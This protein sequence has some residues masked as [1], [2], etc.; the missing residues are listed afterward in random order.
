[1]CFVQRTID[2]RSRTPNSRSLLLVQHTELHAS[3]VNDS[4]RKTVQGVNFAQHRALANATKGRVARAH[5]EVVQRRRY[6]GGPGTKACSGCTGLAAG[7]ATS[8]DKDIVLVDFLRA[9]RT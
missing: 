6:E 2:L 1:M 8:D 9:S 5:T 3:L 7:M 4:A